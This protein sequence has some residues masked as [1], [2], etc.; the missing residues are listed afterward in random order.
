MKGNIQVNS[1]YCG[2]CKKTMKFERNSMVWGCG[3][4]IMVLLGASVGAYFESIFTVLIGVGAWVVLRFVTNES[5]N[6]WRC[7]ECGKKVSKST[8]N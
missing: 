6:P 8:K 7:K 2:K 1:K 5:T 4:I 3:D